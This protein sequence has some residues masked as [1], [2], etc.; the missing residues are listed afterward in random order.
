MPGDI[1]IGK[2]VTSTGLSIDT[3]SI[4]VS[5]GG[6]ASNTTI[7]GVERQNTATMYVSAGGVAVNT[8]V[9]TNSLFSVY[10]GGT[11]TNITE[12]GGMVIVQN[13]AKVTFAPHVFSGRVPYMGAATIHSGTT[14][15]KATVSYI[16]SMFVS[17]GGIA[18]STSIESRGSMY[19]FSGGTASNTTVNYSGF[20][21]VSSGGTANKVMVKESGSFCVE[22]GGKTLDVT[23]SKGLFTVSSGAIV[24]NVTMVGGELY[25]ES[26]A[27]VENITKKKGN[28]YADAG[29]IVTYASGKNKTITLE[30]S[31]DCDN[32]KNNYLYS[33]KQSP[34]LNT[35]VYNSYAEYIS[36]NTTN[37]QLDK[38]AVSHD[39]KTNY[40]GYGDETDFLKISLT[41]AARLAFNLEATGPAKLTLWKLTYAGVDKKGNSKY[42]MKALETVTLKKGQNIASCTLKK[43]PLL[44]TGDYYISVEATSVKKGGD[45]YYNVSV[46]SDSVFYSKGKKYDDSWYDF[47]EDDYSGKGHLGTLTGKKKDLY[48]DWV[49]FGD[50]V[51]YRKFTLSSAAKLSFSVTASDKVTFSICIPVAKSSY[52]HTTV[53]TTKKLQTAKLKKQRGGNSYSAHT[54]GILLEAGDYY[55]CVRSTN[56]EKGG[57][58]DYTVK[59]DTEA[60]VFFT[61]GNNSDD[62]SDLAEKG[63]S[64]KVGS[65]GKVDGKKEKLLEEWVGFGDAVDYKKFTLSSAAKL[66]FAINASDATKFSICRLDSKTD[67]KGNTIYSLKTL[68][69][70]TIKKRG[71]NNYS[72]TTKSLLLDPGDYCFCMKSPNAKKGGS[73][74]YTVNLD[75]G[76]SVFFTMGKNND[77]WDDMA[78]KG[79]AGKVVKLGEISAK[80]TLSDWVG[81]GDEVDYRQFTLE[82]GAKL[83]FDIFTSDAVKFTVYR[84]DSKTDKKGVTT[85]SLKTLQTT[86]LKA[87]DWTRTK[88]LKLD[89]GTYYFSVK[90]TNAKKGGNADY[91]IGLYEF[92]ALP[93]KEKNASALAFMPDEAVGQDPAA[94]FDVSELAMPEMAKDGDAGLVLLS[95]TALAGME[96]PGLDED[97][98]CA[99]PIPVPVTGELFEGLA[100]AASGSSFDP[101]AAPSEA[102][103][104]SSNNDFLLPA[105]GLLA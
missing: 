96:M 26:G 36:Y 30:K 100:T 28:V 38:T 66:N 2:G 24:T 33:A 95:G 57:N 19:V 62:W 37:I 68:Q 104:D 84:L 67:K 27:T 41:Y 17:S 74:E 39:G 1:E 61:K 45:V 87:H 40:V 11:A 65:I 46:N 3:G 4:N 71:K 88:S 75:T 25:I 56:A 93:T 16:G 102:G 82:T 58:A 9:G 51:D 12:D 78:E 15:F 85:Y 31:Q 89:S 54:D 83:R 64:G 7:K 69:S 53:Y 14:A 98:I 80:T 47:F 23:V 8:T 92:N 35:N 18:N 44:N 42:K 49:G 70:T 103:A 63:A 94:G 72:S 60:S 48:E 99:S 13:G 79:A 22:S 73:A 10:P 59:L 29:A 34:T 81:Y 97:G 5:S 21:C 91:E 20:F 77:D 86:K 101:I 6:T 90:S 52:G 43:A 50:D 32:G 55:L 76:K 105:G